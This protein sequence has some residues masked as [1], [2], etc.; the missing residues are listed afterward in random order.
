MLLNNF[1]GGLNTRIA[2]HLLQPNTAQ[3]YTNIDNSS[4]ALLPVKDCTL[5]TQTVDKYFTW[6]E[7]GQ[8][9]ISS[10]TEASYVEYQDILYKTN[11]NSRPTKY[12]G[13]DEYSLGIAGP[14]NNLSLISG[15]SGNLDGTYKYVYTYY[16]SASG[17]ESKP[18]P[19]NAELTVSSESIDVGGFQVSSNAQVDIIRLYR[20]GGTLTDFTLVV[21]KPNNATDFNDN[22]ADVDIA[23]NHILDSYTYGIAPNKLKYLVEAY[24]MLFGA[25]GDKLYYSVIGKPDAWP[26][27]YFIDFDLEITGIAPMQSGL[28]VFTKYKTYIITGTNPDSFSKQLIDGEQGCIS[29]YTINFVANSLTWLSLDGVCVTTGGAFDVISFP[30]LGK[31]SLTGVNNAE[32]HDRVYYISHSGGLLAFDFRYTPVVRTIDKNVDWLHAH[33]NTLYANISGDIYSMFDGEDLEYTY[34]SPIL[35]EGMYSNRKDYKDFYI[36]YNGDITL[37]LYVDG[38]LVNE[39]ELSGNSCFN[40]KALNSAS[41]YGLEIEIVG[42]GEVSEIEYKAQGRQNGR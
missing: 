36:K 11:F 34:K 1:S 25:V 37:R 19:I 28:L 23:G 17:V 16:N 14:T 40:L 29:H 22:V 35:T 10:N 27:A 20:L 38:E 18:N 6:Y 32:V 30:N 15:G 13:T 21:E 42:T 2:P 33:N 31:L 3:V 4:G 41:G 8:E 5:D 7:Y 39:K 24:A 26:E 9:Y 12:D